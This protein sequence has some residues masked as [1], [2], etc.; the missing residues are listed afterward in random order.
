MFQLLGELGKEGD[1]VKVV[2]LFCLCLS[3]SAACM[4]PTDLPWFIPVTI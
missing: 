4:L 3:E 2:V 1:R